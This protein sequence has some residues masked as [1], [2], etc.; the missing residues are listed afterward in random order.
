MCEQR[1]DRLG[2][3]VR[4]PD[5]RGEVGDHQR[6]DDR[7]EAAAGAAARCPGPP[8]RG[9]GRARRGA[10]RRAWS[11]WPSRRSVCARLDRAEDRARGVVAADVLEPVLDLAAPLAVRDHDQVEHPRRHVR[12][13]LRV[14][15]LEQLAQRGLDLG[16]RGVLRSSRRPRPSAIGLRSRATLALAQQDASASSGP[17]EPAGYCGSG[18]GVCAQ[19]SR[20]GSQMR[21]CA[22]TSSSR[23][24]SVASPRIASMISRS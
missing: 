18:P 23:V 5:Q 21:H 19:A 12:L 16:G 11:S 6:V 15:L 10:G 17:S 22:S 24:K 3:A 4:R 1:V 14:A 9:R 8:A 2:V 7:V 20:I 13:V